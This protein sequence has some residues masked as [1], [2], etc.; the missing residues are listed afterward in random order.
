MSLSAIVSDF[1]NLNLNKKNSKLIYLIELFNEASEIYVEE[2]QTSTEIRINSHGFFQKISLEQDD[3]DIYSDHHSLVF[4]AL[5]YAYQCKK[6]SYVSKIN[7]WNH[8]YINFYDLHSLPS[9]IKSLHLEND[10]GLSPNEIE[11]VTELI[12]NEYTSLLRF[13]RSLKKL[14]ITQSVDTASCLIID[15]LSDICKKL[16]ITLH[17]SSKCKYSTFNI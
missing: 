2:H 12:I 17:I 10:I 1:S 5:K 3:Y 7:Y 6:F 13:P 16:D 14:T 11:G 15:Q 9:S 4:S 8:S